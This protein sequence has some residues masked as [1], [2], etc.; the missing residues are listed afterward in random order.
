[1]QNGDSLY[2][3]QV[4][5][6]VSVV[7]NVQHPGTHAIP[8]GRPYTITDAVSDAGGPAPKAKLEGV[9]IARQGPDGKVQQIPVN[10][11]NLGKT[12]ADMPLQ[13]KDVVFVPQSGKADAAQTGSFMNLWFL[14]RNLLRIP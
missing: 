1:M 2:V 3:P 9:V 5:E 13:D 11:K 10:Y 6:R 8:D 4:I 7:G 14:L 12:Q